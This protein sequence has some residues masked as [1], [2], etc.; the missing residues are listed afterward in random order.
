MVIPVVNTGNATAE[1]VVVTYHVIGSGTRYDYKS[2]SGDAVSGS[3]DEVT[4][5]GTATLGN[6]TGGSAK[7]AILLFLCTGE[8]QVEVLITGISGIDENTGEAIPADNKIIPPCSTVLK[9][10]P[11]TVEIKNPYTCQNFRLGANFAVKALITNGSSTETLGNVSATV[12]W[13][14]GSVLYQGAALMGN[15]TKTKDLGNATNHSAL[16]NSQHEITWEF[17]CT[18][19]GDVIFWVTTTTLNPYLTAISSDEVTVHQLDCIDIGIDILSPRT[20][21]Y[22]DGSYEQVYT[23]TTIAT[24]EEFAV[25]ALVNCTGSVG[26]EAGN[27]T[28]CITLPDGVALGE[29][30]TLCKTVG[31]GTMVGGDQE[32]VTWTLHALW[33]GN[34][35]CNINETVRI[36]GN[37]TTTSD[38]CTGNL[39]HPNTDYVDIAIYP[40]AHLVAEIVSI[41]PASPFVV[42]EEFEVKYRV[43]NYGEADAWEVEAVLSVDPAGSVRIAEGE[44]GYT[45]YLGTIAGWKHYSGSD[46]YIEDTFT[47]HCKQAC[48]STIT[49]TPKGNDECGWHWIW[50]YSGAAGYTP[51]WLY[52]DNRSYTDYGGFYKFVSLPG[53]EIDAEFI[54]PA[55]QTV[56]QVVSGGVDLSIDKTA[57]N[58]FPT[59]GQTVKFTVVVTN[60]GPAEATGIL[61]SDAIPGNLTMS[62]HTKT[63]G[64][65][66][67]GV[68]TV[69]SLAAGSS[70]TL[71]INCTVGSVSAITNT[72]TITAL[73]QVD[74]F[75][76]NNTDSVTLNLAAVTSMDIALKTG[77]NLI[78]LPLIP[79]NS[80]IATV[81][82]GV[83]GNVSIVYGY[84]PSAGWKSYIPGGPTPSLTTM[85]DGKGYWIN[86]IAAATLTV[87]GVVNPLPPTTPPAYSVAAG[88]NLIGFKST[89][90]MTAGDYLAAIAGQWT[91]IW[92]YTNG[93]YGA[94]TSSGMLQ[95]G[96]GY[97]IAVTSAGTIFP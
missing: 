37:V 73:G 50:V 34:M 88:W 69:G 93:Q 49:I 19:E 4:G 17:E 68:W 3:F 51:V 52:E 85:V 62:S 2:T 63:Q 94:V 97:W 26:L 7:K 79:N 44:G 31:N 95:P 29:G 84:D 81:L 12:Y 76:D 32:T 87:N 18:A 48:E 42:C 54:E 16:P 45:R 65:Y 6:I 61:V 27:V 55:S 75:S 47:L 20:N 40:A 5:V 91:R 89:T 15:Q 67:G 23:N 30:E 96:G 11:L 80:A 25:T 22:R 53:R 46:S 71:V 39:A 35:T 82:A 58:L 78:S 57:D 66:T 21:G 10:I 33:T 83:L 43:Y 9:Q 28:A 70:A 60:T 59:V 77:W 24:S 13:G 1:N 64:T 72:A 74:P 14:N 86:M 8:G 38:E 92:G 36:S 56:K 41:T 90:A